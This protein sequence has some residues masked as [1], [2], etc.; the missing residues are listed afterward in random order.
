MPGP[1]LE[2]LYGKLVPLNGGQFARVD[3][4][5]VRDSILAPTKQIAAGYPA[6]MPSF[7]DVIPEGD[8]LELVA[9][10]KSLARETPVPL[11]PPALP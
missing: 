8:L 2:G 1:P 6:L 9:Y 11:P 4:A 7:K 10:I 3:D 5:Y